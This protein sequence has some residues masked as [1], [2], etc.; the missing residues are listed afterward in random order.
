MPIQLYEPLVI[1]D[2]PEL[3]WTDSFESKFWSEGTQSAYFKSTP[4]ESYT[5]ATDSQAA[6]ARAFMGANPII[7]ISRLN[8]FRW[9]D[10]GQY[11]FYG[12]T[13]YF[14]YENFWAA[15]QILWYIL[16]GIKQRGSWSGG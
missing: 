5:Q 2:W 8:S 4:A 11:L 16:P 9:S 7:M 12:Q 1:R 6:E 15:Q 10:V 14:F 13:G 3:R